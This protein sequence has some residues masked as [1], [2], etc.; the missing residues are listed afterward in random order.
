VRRKAVSAVAAADIYGVV[1]DGEGSCDE[2]ATEVRRAELRQ[3]RLKQAVAPDV[4]DVVMSFAGSGRRSIAET[5]AIDFDKGTVRCGDCGHVHC[6]PQDNLLKHL[7]EVKAALRTAGPVRGEDY[8]VGRFHLRQLCCSNC[9]S[10][11]DVQVAL[12]G[13]PRPYFRIDDWPAAAA[14]E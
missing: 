11:V 4:G 12:D 13:A 14:A 8:D 1:L 2:K 9:G 10:L 7:R 3:A 5:L 6:R